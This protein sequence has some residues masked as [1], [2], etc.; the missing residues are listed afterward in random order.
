[1]SKLTINLLQPELMPEKP[2]LTLTR[3]VSLW[4]VVFLVMAVWALWS[5]Q[6]A[7][8]LT[9]KVNEL[10][11]Q[12]T[13]LQQQKSALELRV[14][15]HKADSLLVEQLST[16]KL[17]LDNKQAL[18]KQLTDRSSVRASGFSNA[19]S[20]LSAMHHADISLQE[21]TM[22]GDYLR[23]AGTAKSPNSVPSWLAGFERSTFLSGHSFSHF[24]LKEN[25]Q[26]H[27]DFVVSSHK[28]QKGDK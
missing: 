4:C 25:E 17:L 16:M 15:N 14:A 21:I 3:V 7:N 20:E 11:V 19:M 5:Q 10:T 2:L 1:M 24:S 8:R 27:T 18:H 26:K 28:Q 23:F 13:A 22:D 12:D 6:S 9:I